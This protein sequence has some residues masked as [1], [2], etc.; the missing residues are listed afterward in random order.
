MGL[1]HINRKVGLL[2]L[3]FAQNFKNLVSSIN[4]I[5]KLKIK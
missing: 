2:K 3:G 4:K 5:W 1:G